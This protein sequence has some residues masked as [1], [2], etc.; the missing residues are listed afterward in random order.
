MVST[1]PVFLLVA[2]AAPSLL[3]QVRGLQS[4]GIKLA[5]PEPMTGGVS[6]LGGS[7]TE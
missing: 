4:I 1:I 6:F 5:D 2:S 7:F 3:A